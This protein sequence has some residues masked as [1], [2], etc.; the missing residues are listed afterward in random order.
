MLNL[1]FIL[2]ITRITPAKMPANFQRIL[3]TI[4]C[5]GFSSQKTI[6]VPEIVI[7]DK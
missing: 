7:L 4:F 6:L 2:L 1:H 5:S 3:C